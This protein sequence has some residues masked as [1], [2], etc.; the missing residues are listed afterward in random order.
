MRL[1]KLKRKPG[2]NPVAHYGITTDHGEL[3]HQDLERYARLLKDETLTS[4][5][6]LWFILTSSHLI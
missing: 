2:I 6:A 5:V 4:Y 3:L 1:Q